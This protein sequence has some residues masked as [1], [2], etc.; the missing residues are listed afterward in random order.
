[1]FVPISDCGR[2]VIDE[3][4]GVDKLIS[5]LKS[6][7]QNTAE[8]SEKLRTVAVGFLLNLTNTHGE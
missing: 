3:N 5:L 1:M 7:L 8:G 4:S 2:N 6:Q